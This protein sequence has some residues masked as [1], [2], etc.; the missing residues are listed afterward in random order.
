M[1]SK[2]VLFG[3]HTSSFALQAKKPGEEII[4]QLRTTSRDNISVPF[5]QENIVVVLNMQHLRN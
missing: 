2:N 5:R 1:P 3:T 4:S